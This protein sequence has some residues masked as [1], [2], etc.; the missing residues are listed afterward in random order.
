MAAILAI[1]VGVV[2]LA[3]EHFEPDDRGGFFPLADTRALLGPLLEGGRAPCQGETPSSV[4]ILKGGGAHAPP[5]NSRRCGRRG[6]H[7]QDDNEKARPGWVLERAD[8]VHASGVRIR[9]A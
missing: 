4:A 3:L 8:C 5:E 1:G 9:T 6:V 2:A 7:A